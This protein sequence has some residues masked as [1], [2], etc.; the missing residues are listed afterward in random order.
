MRPLLLVVAVALG[1]TPALGEPAVSPT[2]VVIE[3]FSSQ[4]CSSCPPAERLLARIA[5]AGEVGGR[6]VIPLAFH[7]DYWDDL[8]WA[9]PFALPAWTARQQAYAADRVFTP[10]LVVGGQASVVGSQVGPVSH[11]IAT[12]PATAPLAATGRWSGNQLTITA[13]AP[14]D[15]DVFVAV[16]QDGLT[17]EVARGENRGETL[18]GERVVRRFERVAAAGHA[19]TL[20]VTLDPAWQRTGAVAFAQR[21]DHRITAV[22]L[23]PR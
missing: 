10:E 17:T 4:G 5:A 21:P 9:D 23:L 2:P 15:A 19:A 6:P 11:A 22:A 13:T 20:T 12:A 14:A 16:W 3:L 7:V 18:R 8:G 1:C